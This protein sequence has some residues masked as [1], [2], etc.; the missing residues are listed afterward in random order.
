MMLTFQRCSS[1]VVLIEPIN[2]THF[3]AVPDAT[4][5]LRSLKTV[6]RQQRFHAAMERCVVLG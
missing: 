2:Q 1:A 5:S 3:G 6:L 4:F